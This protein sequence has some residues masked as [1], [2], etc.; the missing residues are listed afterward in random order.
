MCRTYNTIGSL[1]TLKLRLKE[2]NINDFKSLKEVMNFQKSYANNRQQLISYH[3]NLIE[4]EKNILQ[5]N[6]QNLNT[7][8]E[9]QKQQSVQ[10]LT[11]E[12]DE[13]KQLLSVL[14]NNSS[15]SLFKKLINIFKHWKYKREIK[16]KE[17]NFDIEVKLSISNLVEDYESKNNRYEFVTSN[18]DEAVNQSAQLLLSELERKKK[19]IDE[20][21]SF[22]YGALGE[23]KVVKILE[24]LSDEYYL[25]NDFNVTLSPAIYNKQEKDYIKSV[26]ID[27]ILVAPSGIFLIETKNWSEKSLENLNLRSPVKQI[28]RTNYVLFYLL[29]NEMSNYHLSLDGHH[30]G[31]KKIP[32]KNLIV[33][34]NTKPKEE[35][36]YVKILTTNELLG[37]VNYFK[38]ILSSIE[39]K[40]IADAVLQINN[41]LKKDHFVL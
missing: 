11:S 40:K 5:L 12:I 14:R 39:T 1:T 3:E 19:T 17:N 28:R 4:Q 38:P 32:I 8:I 37:Y 21:N 15:R 22:I 35:F 16:K 24:T 18:F 20:L 27:H 41:E 30:W 33:L 29:N 31:D 10:R 6:L 25:I 7:E 13:L 34:T 9:E 23:N 26:Q 36:Q 2:N